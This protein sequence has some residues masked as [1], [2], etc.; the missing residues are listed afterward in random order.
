MAADGSAVENITISNDSVGLELRKKL[1]KRLI[2][3]TA[4]LPRPPMGIREDNN[5]PI[6]D[7]N[8]ISSDIR[9]L[10]LVYRPNN[11]SI[12]D[13]DS[14]QENPVTVFDALSSLLNRPKRDSKTPGG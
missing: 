14:L 2:G 7:A 10:R 4:G 12:T 1:E 13:L 6:R 3:L 5:Y 8:I 11:A 9:G